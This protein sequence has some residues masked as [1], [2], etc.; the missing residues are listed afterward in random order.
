MKLSGGGN[1]SITGA[2]QGTHNYSLYL[3]GNLR[4][5][6]GKTKVLPVGK[7]MFATPT[8][9]IASL[10]SNT[11]TIDVASGNPCEIDGT[12]T[13]DTSSGTYGDIVVDCDTLVFGGTLIAHL[14][15]PSS[16]VNDELIVNGVLDLTSTSELDTPIDGTASN[17]NTWTVLTASGGIENQF[18][19]VYPITN[20]HWQ[21]STDSIT[22]TYGY[23]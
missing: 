19:Y 13:I 21:Q 23:T 18:S 4:S 7:G 6:D 1:L 5:I 11:L 14:S 15:G 10:D 9:T 8:S 20:L 3:E 17:G 12:V 22:E 16:G 2:E